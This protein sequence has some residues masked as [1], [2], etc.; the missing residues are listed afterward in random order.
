MGILH[1]PPPAAQGRVTAGS[2]PVTAG[3]AASAPLPGAGLDGRLAAA[4]PSLSQLPP[5][6]A[7]GGPGSA[8]SAGVTVAPGTAA[9]ASSAAAESL[10]SLPNDAVSRAG[11]VMRDATADGS[12]LGL[13][14]ARPDL[15]EPEERREY[16]IVSV[17]DEADEDL[18]S[19]LLDATPPVRGAERRGHMR[20]PCEGGWGDVDD[21]RLTCLAQPSHRFVCGEPLAL[22]TGSPPA[23]FLRPPVM[24]AMDRPGRHP[25][26]GHQQPV[27]TQR[28]WHKAARPG[29]A[30]DSAQGRSRMRH[31]RS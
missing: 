3:G 11:A 25:C 27:R 13:D 22:P 6:V 15:E 20:M 10:L 28:G 7:A 29:A 31:A 23:P 1:P 19:L 5:A 17:D 9:A 12:M 8:A 30:P 24:A 16:Y 26:R 2:L 14:T 21:G 18:Y 4:G